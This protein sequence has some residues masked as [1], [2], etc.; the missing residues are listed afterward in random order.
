MTR[1]V[2]AAARRTPIGRI[3]GALGAL[4]VE[5]LAAPLIGALLADAGFDGGDIDDVIL[6][7]AAGP[8]GNPARVAALAAGLPLSVPGVTVHAY[9][10][11]LH[12]Y[13]KF[14]FVCFDVATWYLHR[15]CLI[16]PSFCPT[17][18]NVHRLVD[19]LPTTAY[20]ALYVI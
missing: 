2:I 6:G 14:D 11:R 20:N 10:L 17:L 4:P 1:A 15:L 18:H 13:T 12:R 3:G 8:G 5:D 16:D 7:N 9:L 19:S